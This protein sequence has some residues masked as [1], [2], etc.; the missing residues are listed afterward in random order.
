MHTNNLPPPYLPTAPRSRFDGFLPQGGPE[1][2]KERRES[3][4]KASVEASLLEEGKRDE[5]SQALQKKDW[6]V[7]FKRVWDNG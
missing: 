2:E 6:L 5:V 1:A 3:F 4:V 7:K